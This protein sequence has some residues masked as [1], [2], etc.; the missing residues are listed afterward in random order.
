MDIWNLPEVSGLHEVYVCAVAGLP[1]SSAAAI[2][3]TKCESMA[4]K[5]KM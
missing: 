1:Q 4:L 3:S 5:Y 2:A